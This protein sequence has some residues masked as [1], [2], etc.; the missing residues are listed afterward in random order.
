M[1]AASV[2]FGEPPYRYMLHVELASGRELTIQANNFKVDSSDGLMLVK[3]SDDDLPE[4][5]VAIFSVVSF[6]KSQP[7]NKLL[8]EFAGVE[9]S[10]RAFN[11]VNSMG[12]TTLA[13]LS[14]HSERE[15]IMTPGVGVGTV[16]ELK[17]LLFSHGL[18]L[19]REDGKV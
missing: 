18:R 15:L 2:R 19:R 13:D 8:K 4:D 16:N 5:T 6:V 9:I 1:H 11:S 3:V 17:S 12:M 14:A 10:M 7:R